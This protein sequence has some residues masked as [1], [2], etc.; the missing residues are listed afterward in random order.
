MN[1]AKLTTRRGHT[2]NRCCEY[3][4]RLKGENGVGR[5]SDARATE[6]STNQKAKNEVLSDASELS[7]RIIASGI[8]I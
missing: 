6:S 7:C 2:P 8:C 4:R 5:R 1:S 3:S